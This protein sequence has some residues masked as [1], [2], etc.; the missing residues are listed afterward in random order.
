[1]I[2][3]QTYLTT[4]AISVKQPFDLIAASVNMDSNEIFAAIAKAAS[5]AWARRWRLC[6]RSAISLR[7]R[8]SLL[9]CALRTFT[10]ECSE[11]AQI[12]WL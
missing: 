6:G 9:S 3:R 4:P 11:V 1:M 5:S 2:D 8:R 10:L 7:L 12:H